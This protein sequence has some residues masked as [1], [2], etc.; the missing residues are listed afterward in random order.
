MSNQEVL[1]TPIKDW[2]VFA[3]CKSFLIDLSV[4]DELIIIG[5]HS[6]RCGFS[7]QHTHRYGVRPTHS[8]RHRHPHC[9]GHH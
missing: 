1:D 2:D 5:G 9:P 4:N 6:R 8:R 3:N 7:H